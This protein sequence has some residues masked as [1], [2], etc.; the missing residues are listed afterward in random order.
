MYVRTYDN[1]ARNC[2]QD[3][4]DKP[5]SSD[6]TAFDKSLVPDDEFEQVPIS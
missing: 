2:T 1:R 5:K 6:P 4:N 3:N